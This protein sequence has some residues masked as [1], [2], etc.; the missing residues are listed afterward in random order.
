MTPRPRTR[1]VGKTVLLTRRHYLLPHA[2]REHRPLITARRSSSAPMGSAARIELTTSAVSMRLGADD[3]RP[4]VR[5]AAPV[6]LASSDLAMHGAQLD[7]HL[8]RTSS[9]N[10]LARSVSRTS[11]WRGRGKPRHPDCVC[12]R[13]RQTVLAEAWR[14]VQSRA[15]AFVVLPRARRLA[16]N[17]RVLRKVWERIRLTARRARR[18]RGPGCRRSA[19]RP[20]GSECSRP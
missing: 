5:R 17:R 4:R 2:S 10:P 20:E 18:C 8:P 3:S 14:R 19:R 9:T 13:E 11:A 12:H 7:A 16:L 6:H 15:A 1:G